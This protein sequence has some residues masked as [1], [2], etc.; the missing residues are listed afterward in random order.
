MYT[1]NAMVLELI[2]LLGCLF[3]QL[4]I[5]LC[6]QVIRAWKTRELLKSKLQV[7]QATEKQKHTL[8]GVV[9]EAGR[10]CGQAAEDLAE[11]MLRMEELELKVRCPTPPAPLRP[12]SGIWLTYIVLDA[13]KSVHG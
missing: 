11:Y 2:Y 10:V 5:C 3:K 12:F 7:A 4:L 9:A 6:Y 13:E 1:S 8:E